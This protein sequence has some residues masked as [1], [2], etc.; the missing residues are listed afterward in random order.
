MEDTTT[1]NVTV[2]FYF[3]DT[4]SDIINQ[5]IDDETFEADF[6]VALEEQIEIQLGSST[7]EDTVV[8]YIV[9]EEE[10]DV[11]IETW[12]EWDDTILSIALGLI[13]AVSAL[14]LVSGYL[15]AKCRAADDFKY[16]AVLLF[17]V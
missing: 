5:L 9:Y 4:N 1:Y 7:G 12:Q 3:D 14:L 13:V 17:G 8:I 15:Q 2:T 16:F 11:L 6:Q 10:V